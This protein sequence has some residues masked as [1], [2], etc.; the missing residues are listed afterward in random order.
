MALVLLDGEYLDAVVHRGAVDVADPVGP[1]G[2][3]FL[4]LLVTIDH[5]GWL[6]PPGE[7]HP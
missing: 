4:H 5:H 7:N 6:A 2:Q 1:A 3:G